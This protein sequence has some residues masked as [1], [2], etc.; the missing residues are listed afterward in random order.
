MLPLLLIWLILL[1]ALV[2]FC[3]RDWR[4]GGALVLGY[5]L[6]VSLIHVPGVLPYL[7]QD[8]LAGADVTELGFIATLIGLTAF[9]VGAAASRMTTRKV[10]PVSE[11]PPELIEKFGTRALVMGVISYFVLIPVAARAP[12]LTS[13]VSPFGTL[14]VIG[15]W[16]RLYGAAQRGGLERTARTLL[17]LPLLPLATLGTA[18]FIGYGVNW[19]IAV[20]AFFFIISRYRALFYVAAP[21]VIFFGLSFF[22]AYMGERTGIRDLV[23]NENAGVGER[24]ERIS[25]IFTRFQPLDLTNTEHVKALVDRLDQNMIVGQGV[26]RHESGEA[27]FL[28]G[29][30]VPWWT[31]VP[32]A[33]WPDKP[34]VGGGGEIVSN[35]TGR[36][37]AEGT[38]VGAGQVLE[39]YMNFGY[40]GVVIGFF[41]LG[42]GLMRL[43]RGVMDGLRRGDLKLVLRCAMPGLSMLQPGG[44]LTEIAVITVASVV[45]AYFITR[46]KVFGVPDLV[47]RRPDPRPAPA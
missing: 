42:F 19:V 45:G 43:D 37:F 39:F 2:W 11:P 47:S 44:N 6:S 16:M 28:Y 20:L 38:S 24:L 18:G 32:R 33:V 46:I 13:L 3:F 41:A 22:V 29:N 4:R 15:L 30:S 21:L 14:L 27:P 8:W 7:A 10:M 17:L 35:F 31:L 25:E 36:H 40:P 26:D 1:V 9:V 23:W 5:F 12:S 34:D